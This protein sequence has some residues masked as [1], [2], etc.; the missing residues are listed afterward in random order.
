MIS[1]CRRAPEISGA[2]LD[3]VQIEEIKGIKICRQ[4]RAKWDED[5]DERID[6]SGRKYYWLVGKFT[7]LEESHDTDQAALNDGYISVVP[8]K[9]D[10]TDYDALD[11]LKN[12][13]L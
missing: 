3:F 10:M 8:I 12:M 1:I 2:L 11:V 13:N 6:P 4:A 9:F 7:L 5:F